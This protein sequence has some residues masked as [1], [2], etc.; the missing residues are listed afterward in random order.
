MPNMLKITHLDEKQLEKLLKNNKWQIDKKASG[1]I[2]SC[3]T[4][5]K[6]KRGK[7][8]L[9]IIKEVSN[10]AKEILVHILLLG[11]E[12][13]EKGK[14]NIRNLIE[15]CS[16]LQELHSCLETIIHAPHLF[17]ENKT[18]ALLET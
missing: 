8:R 3:H 4:G 15:T 5:I 2:S 12:N 17:L 18:K 7:Y 14:E 9:S 11:Q 16:N 6:A 10:E 1:K 13:K